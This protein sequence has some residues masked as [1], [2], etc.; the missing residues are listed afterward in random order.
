LFMTTLDGTVL[1]VALPALQRNLGASPADLQWTVAGF[2]LFRACGIFLCGALADRFGRKRLFCIGLVVFTLGS[3]ACG[4]APNLG[5]L[6]GFRC[7]QGFGSAILTPSSLAII[8]STFTDQRRRAWAVGMWNVAAGV[9]T[10]AGPVIGGVLVQYFGWRSVFIIN[11]PIGI[12]ALFGTRIL[13]ES[14][15]EIPRRFDVGGQL[16]IGLGLVTLTYALITAPTKGWTSPLI[17]LL[18]VLSLFSWC[19]FLFVQRSSDHPLIGMQYLK[20]PA[21]A[22]GALLAI[23]AFTV[24]SGFQFLNTLYLQEVRNF[25][26]LITGLVSLPLAVTV[27]I[28]A[29]I[30]GRM[31]GRRGPRGS[32]VIASCSLTAGMVLLTVFATSSVSL[33]ALIFGYL[34]LGVGFG[35]INTPITT[36]AISSMPRERAGVAGAVSTTGRQIGAN[37]GVALIGSIAFS[38]GGT[39]GA[40]KRSGFGRVQAGDFVHGLRYGYGVAAILAGLGI[41]VALWAFRNWQAHSDE[42]RTI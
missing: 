37:L 16:T 40:P 3:L 5:T 27:V 14:K 13:A 31:T 29:P 24:L 32:A 41:A 8:T 9:S 19:G 2:A 1:N 34:V 28:F 15:A 20:R 22:G 38:V 36:A 23:L 25:S 39:F 11:L 33:V 18:L 7:F 30:A 6:I 26:P 42:E 12:A 17:L 10:T 35:L 21:L 4:V